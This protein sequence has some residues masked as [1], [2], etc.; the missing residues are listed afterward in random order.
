MRRFPIHLYQRLII[1]VNLPFSVLVVS[2]C[3]FKKWRS[4][5]LGSRPPL[6]VDGNITK[7]A[8]RSSQSSDMHACD[9]HNS[10]HFSQHF[11]TTVNVTPRFGRVWSR[12]F[13]DPMIVWPRRQHT[14]FC[15]IAARYYTP[16]SQF[17]GVGSLLSRTQLLYASS[18]A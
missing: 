13:H 3:F 18:L 9:F 17:Q 7:K 10:V 14:A 11:P 15:F 4:H 1:H 6:R 5:G 8:A 2:V 16:G 12:Q